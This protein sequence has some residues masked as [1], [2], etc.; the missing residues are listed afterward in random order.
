M[1]TSAGHMLQQ[2]KSRLQTQLKRLVNTDLKEICRAYHKGVSGNKAELQKRC[3]D[4]EYG[5]HK[6][7]TNASWTWLDSL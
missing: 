2:T 7:D 4:S 6:D 3:L 5:T 1:A